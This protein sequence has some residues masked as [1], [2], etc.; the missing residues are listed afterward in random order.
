MWPIPQFPTDLVTFPEKILLCIVGKIPEIFRVN[1]YCGI[2]FSKAPDQER[3]LHWGDKNKFWTIFFNHF[4]QFFRHKFWNFLL[5]NSFPNYRR[6]L[7]SLLAT[8]LPIVETFSNM[9]VLVF[10]F[11]AEKKS[12]WETASRY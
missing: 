9:K 11:A 4:R 2:C 5:K 6:G 8:R 12:S 3:I 7:A 10:V 1:F